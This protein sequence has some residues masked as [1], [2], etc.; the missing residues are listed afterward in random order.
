[1]PYY[2]TVSGFRTYHTARG[3]STDAYS[4]SE[5]EIRLLIASEWLD[6]RFG[7]RYTGLKKG[8]RDQIRDWPRTMGIDKDGWW[9]PDTL[10]PT[11]VENA[12][13][14]A[15]LEE[16]EAP[17]A[18]NKN[19]TASQYSQVSV[20]GA[21]HVQYLQ[22]RGVSDVQTRFTAVEQAL[23]PVLTGLGGGLS[24]EGVR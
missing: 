21:L 10:I 11:E 20:T 2:G 19:F 8:N 17:G 3:V 1:M 24:G 5:V 18:L 15:A 14:E 6:G 4:D 16:L 22:N 12:T 9:I 23:A 7:S 13:Y